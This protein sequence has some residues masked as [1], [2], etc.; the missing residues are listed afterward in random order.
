MGKNKVIVQFKAEAQDDL[1]RLFQIEETLFQAFSQCNDG[2]VDG[3]DIGQGKFNIFIHPRK[4]WGPVLER[5]EAFLK[6]R[7][8][9]ADA[10]IV[11]FHG[12][13]KRYEV[14]HPAAH[15][16]GFAL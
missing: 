8:A 15:P 1:D 5:V 4:S 11:K 7:G 13:T 14:V 10:V 9:L 16:S 12:K 2:I 6:L 3:H